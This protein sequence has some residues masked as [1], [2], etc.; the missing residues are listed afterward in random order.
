[1]VAMAVTSRLC[2]ISVVMFTCEVCQNM[3]E[4]NKALEDHFISLH[5]TKSKFSCTKCE[6]VIGEEA[7]L[8]AHM[9][10]YHKAIRVDI[11]LNDQN[12]LSCS[13][14]KYICKLNIQMRNHMKR[15]H[16]LIDCEEP[17]V[18]PCEKC[19]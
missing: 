2:V 13:R 12:V 18:I 14:C 4:N 3:F 1:M 16:T 17:N 11:D 7:E 9:Q 5:A 10:S 6:E 15:A 8:L 19:D